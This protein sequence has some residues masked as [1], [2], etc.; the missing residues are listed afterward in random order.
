M[1][2]NWEETGKTVKR[3]KTRVTLSFLVKDIEPGYLGP[4]GGLERGLEDRICDW[5]MRSEMKSQNWE[6]A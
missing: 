5:L 1:S 3:H 4:R 6:G 2:T